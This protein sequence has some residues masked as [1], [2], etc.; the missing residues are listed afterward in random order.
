MKQGDFETFGQWLSN[1]MLTVGLSPKDFS[2]CLGSSD[3]LYIKRVCDNQSR[4]QMKDWP[5]ASK[6]LQLRLD[7][8]LIV[9]EY[10]HPDWVKEY[11]LFISNCLRYLLWRVEQNQDKTQPWIESLLSFSLEEIIEPACSGRFDS[12][13]QRRKV[14]RRSISTAP[15]QEQR[16]Q[17]RRLTDLIHHLKSQLG[18]IAWFALVV[19]GLF[20]PHGWCL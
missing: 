17:P 20:M 16:G 4:L 13:A 18:V 3:L 14:D 6:H 15:E 7:E 10:F 8:F 9:I 1:H 12:T 5:T 11:D 19:S 2:S